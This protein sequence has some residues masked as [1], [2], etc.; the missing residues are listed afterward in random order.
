VDVLADKSMADAPQDENEEHKRIQQLKNAKCAQCR[1][2]AKN[3][4]YNPIH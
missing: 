3:R 4:A 1:R 2:N